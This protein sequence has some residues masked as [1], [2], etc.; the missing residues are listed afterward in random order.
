MGG[1]LAG[2]NPST[3]QPNAGGYQMPAPANGQTSIINGFS[4]TP[5]QAFVNAGQQLTNSQQPEQQ[6]GGFEMPPPQQDKL[7][8][9][10]FGKAYELDPNATYYHGLGGIKRAEVL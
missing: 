8:T 10:K 9:Y 1:G 2:F 7:V 6:G 5:E 3:G 4:M